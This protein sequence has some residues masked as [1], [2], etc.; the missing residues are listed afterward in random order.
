MT[1][2]YPLSSIMKYYTDIELFLFDVIRAFKVTKYQ[3][4]K[5]FALTS[6][7]SNA[8]QERSISNFCV[9]FELH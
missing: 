7:W 2:T 4:M 3:R 8:R 9:Q 5:P 6:H 1:R